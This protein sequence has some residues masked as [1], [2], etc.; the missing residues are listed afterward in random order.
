MRYLSITLLILTISSPVAARDPVVEVPQKDE[1]FNISDKSLVFF[2]DSRIIK[3]NEIEQDK[4]KLTQENRINAGLY[5]GSVWFKLIISNPNPDR[6]SVFLELSQ[7]LLGSAFL[8]SKTALNTWEVLKQGLSGPRERIKFRRPIF[9]I[10]LEAGELKILYLKTQSEFAYSTRILLHGSK[11][12]QKMKR[13][14]EK[15]SSINLGIVIGSCLYSLFLLIAIRER[16]ALSM[17]LLN[18]LVYLPISEGV[19]LTLAETL[20]QHFETP[21]KNIYMMAKL[22][23][24]CLMIE[25]TIQV[26]RPSKN[27]VARRILVTSFW[28]NI[29]MIPLLFFLETPLFNG[30]QNLLVIIPMVLGICIIS[31]RG[32][33]RKKKQVILFSIGWIPILALLLDTVLSGL[34]QSNPFEGGFLAVVSMQ[35]IFFSMAVAYLINELKGEKFKTELAHSKEVD[36]LNMKLKKALEDQSLKLDEATQQLIISSHKAGRSNVASGILHNIGNIGTSLRLQTQLLRQ[37]QSNEEEERL[38]KL[39]ELLGDSDSDQVLMTKKSTI[40]KY[41]LALA[42]SMSQSRRRRI[43]EIGNILEYIE[44]IEGLTASQKELARESKLTQIFAIENIIRTVIVSVDADIKLSDIMLNIE[45]KGIELKSDPVKIYGI[46]ECLIK[47]SIESIRELSGQREISISATK[48]PTGVRI[49]IQDNGAGIDYP[50]HDRIF[51]F[52]YTLKTGHKG[53]GLH[54]AANDCSSIGGTLILLESIPYEK[55]IFQLH[56]PQENLALKKEEAA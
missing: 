44:Q 28:V 37:N 39:A 13:L 54:N 32:L 3:I 47:N 23:F 24:P 27:G 26:C 16:I 10:S 51:R 6:R 43:D 25:F 2:D 22:I 17:V 48:L 50:N 19:A 42:N 34:T 18:F 20:Y 46:L 31:F 40:R 55:T 33:I 36:N 14:S 12:Y 38:H 7:D 5:T 49:E 11:A 21:Y 29:L 45:C 4:W 15:A 35:A 53:Y 52:G 1:T 41:I 30:F 8:Y 9:E 56:I